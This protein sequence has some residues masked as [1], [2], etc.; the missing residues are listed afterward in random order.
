MEGLES[1]DISKIQGNT[2]KSD[3]IVQSSVEELSRRSQDDVSDK[4][5]RNQKSGS[6][7]E[8]TEKYFAIAKKKRQI[9]KD[10]TTLCFHAEK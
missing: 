6:V 10:I 3:A 9:C 8:V 4:V 1:C 7:G 2:F 5:V